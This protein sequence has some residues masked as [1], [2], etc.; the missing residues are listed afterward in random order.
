MWDVIVRFEG[1]GTP[2]GEGVGGSGVGD[3]E[4]RCSEVSE[5]FVGQEERISEAEE[6]Y[7][8]IIC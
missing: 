4:R 1:S 7:G 8:L 5:A 2:N 6:R 3:G